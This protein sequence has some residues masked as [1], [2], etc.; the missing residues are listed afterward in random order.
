MTRKLRN[1]LIVLVVLIGVG[2]FAYPIVSNYIFVRNASTITEDYEE[3]VEKT[4]D[5]ALTA[6]LK[7]AQEYNKTLEGAPARDPFV[8]GSGM[9]QSENYAKI[10]N[11]DDTGIMGYITIPKIG[12]KLSIYHGTA[13]RTLQEGVGHLEGS[14]LPIGGVGSHS[15]LT[16]HSGL[17]QAKMFTDLEKLGKNDIFYV[18]ILGQTLAYRVDQIKTVLPEEASNLRRVSNEDYCTLVTC[19]PIGVN[20]HRLLV[21]GKRTEYIPEEHETLIRTSR[22]V[23]QWFTGWNMVIGLA[24]GAAAMILFLLLVIIKKRRENRWRKRKQYWWNEEDGFLP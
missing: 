10:L 11:L 6:A 1:F 3:A 9:V 8:P 2:L 12:V 4:D 5:K 24:V 15:V 22:P 21:R 16:G 19:T 14:S 20:T 18:Y 17:V 13:E 7:E 23:V